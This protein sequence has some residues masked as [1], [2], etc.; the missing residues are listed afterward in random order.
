MI[1][2]RQ[3]TA[4][5]DLVCSV[6]A[7]DGHLDYLVVPGMTKDCLIRE[8][9]GAAFQETRV[10]GQ[11]MHSATVAAQLFYQDLLKTTLISFVFNTGP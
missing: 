1:A 4:H 5:P 2:I 8:F 7:H 9:K 10:L 6:V 11:L 3:L